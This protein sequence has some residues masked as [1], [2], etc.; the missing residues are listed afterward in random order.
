M[1]KKKSTEGRGYAAVITFNL[2]SVEVIARDPAR[3]CSGSSPIVIASTAH[4]RFVLY[5]GGVVKYHGEDIA[6][7]ELAAMFFA[8]NLLEMTK[9]AAP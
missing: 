4:D 8:Q 9:G 5:P 3:P 1:S 7:E 6:V 2:R